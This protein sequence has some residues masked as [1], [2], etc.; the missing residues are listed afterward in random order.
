M[1]VFIKNMVCP[2]CIIVVRKIFSDLDIEFNVILLGEVELQQ[3]LSDETLHLLSIKLKEV[4]LELLQEPNQ[5]LVET[6]KKLI[7]EKVQM[8]NIEPH[9]PP[10]TKPNKPAP[11][12]DAD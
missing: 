6:I 1:K 2:R 7:I 9:F 11:S 3:K 8:N 4:G 10:M 12:A 5:L